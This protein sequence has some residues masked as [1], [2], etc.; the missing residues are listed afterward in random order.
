MT[1]GPCVECGKPAGWGAAKVGH[2]MDFRTT[3]P[4][5]GVR[6]YIH[7]ACYQKRYGDKKR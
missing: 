4:V 2:R 7:E 3:F 5:D 6:E 1:W